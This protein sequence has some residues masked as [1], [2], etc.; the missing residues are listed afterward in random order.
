MAF[1]ERLVDSIVRFLD[2]NGDYVQGRLERGKRIGKRYVDGCQT[3]I[4]T[5]IKPFFRDTLLCDVNTSL[6]EQLCAPFPAGMLTLKTAI[7]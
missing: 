7:P 6:L 4:R 3:K 2:W 1:G 5:H